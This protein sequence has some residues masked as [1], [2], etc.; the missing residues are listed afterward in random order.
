[1]PQAPPAE[2]TS[3]KQQAPQ[4]QRTS[5]PQQALQMHPLRT[6]KLLGSPI[7]LLAAVDATSSASMLTGLVAHAMAP[8][9]SAVVSRA[10]SHNTC[11]THAKYQMCLQEMIPATSSASMATGL[12]ARARATSAPAVVSRPLS[13]TLL[14]AAEFLLLSSGPSKHCSA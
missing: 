10:A 11:R 3:M 2:R 6:W 8:P 1:M 12:V 4:A 5:M 7:S 9:A 14:E 13:P